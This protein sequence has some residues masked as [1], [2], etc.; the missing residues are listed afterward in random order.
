MDKGFFEEAPRERCDSE[1]REEREEGYDYVAEAVKPR[2][3]VE[4]NAVSKK[5]EGVVQEI[6]AVGNATEPA[7][8][9]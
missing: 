3:G 9:A 1:S 2:L 6:N 7:E 8:R 5:V 4:N